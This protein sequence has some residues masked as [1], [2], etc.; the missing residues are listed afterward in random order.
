MVEILVASV[1]GLCIV[2]MLVGA[3]LSISYGAHAEAAPASDERFD[4]VTAHSWH[5]YS[6]AYAH[7]HR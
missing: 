6:P 3:Y 2:G 5:V 4:P 1:Q 7:A